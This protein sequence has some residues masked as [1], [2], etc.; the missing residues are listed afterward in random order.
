M[1]LTKTTSKIQTKMS[2]NL[3]DNVSKTV[4]K[5]VS[6]NTSNNI[7]V[8]PQL[9]NKYCPIIKPVKL[10]GDKWVLPIIKEMIDGAERFNQIKEGIPGITGRTLSAKLKYLVQEN[11][12]ERVCGTEEVLKLKPEYR[13]TKFGKALQPIIVEIEKFG[14]KFMC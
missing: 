13:L 1:P 14:E 2:K 9:A 8:N 6:K 10:I 3:P 4:S 11:L 12:I 7:A 5:T